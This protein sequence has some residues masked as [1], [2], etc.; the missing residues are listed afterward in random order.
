MISYIVGRNLGHLS[1]CVATVSKFKKIS[2]KGIKIYTYPHSHAWLRSNL[3]KVKIGTH[4]RKKLKKMS[5]TLLKSDLIIH[6]W[7]EEVQKLKENRVNQKCIISGIYHSDMA[8][9]KNDTVWT[10]K[11]KE[12]VRDISQNTT[13]IF[14]HINL[15]QPKEKP[16]LSTLYVPIPIIVREQTMNPEKV[17]KILGI[18]KKEPFLL[19]QM[20]GGVGKFRYK[21]M[22]DWYEK[23]NKLRTPYR[24][25]IANQFGKRDFKFGK[26]IIQAPLFDNGRDLVNASEMVISKPG[27]GILVDC[28]STGTPLLALPADSKEREVKNLMLRDLIRSDVCLASKKFS[29][30]DLSKRILEVSDEEKR[31][32]K[33]FKKLPQNGAEIMAKSIKLLSNHNLKELPDVYGKVLQLTPYKT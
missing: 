31:F 7:R 14:F 26:H 28:I 3:H 17:K 23:I 1:R 12:Q 22:K 27:M 10:R 5:S 32:K 33:A 29:S 11:F 15:T 9:T 30:K 24:I 6:D 18:P 8:I 21:F 13:D 16:K 4:D 19:V 25:V 20:G 2:K